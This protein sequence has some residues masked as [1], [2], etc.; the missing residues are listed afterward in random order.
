[1][2]L[3][4]KKET[5]TF[6]NISSK[7]HSPFAYRSSQEVLEKKFFQ[8]FQFYFERMTQRAKSD[9]TVTCQKMNY[10]S[11]HIRAE[12]GDINYAISGE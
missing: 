6:L 1:M 4:S 10:I 3:H 9:T 5:I 2:S 7:R 8:L 12:K 11:E